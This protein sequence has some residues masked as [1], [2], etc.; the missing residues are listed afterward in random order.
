[1]AT[2]SITATI[3][4]GISRRLPLRPRRAGG[5]R[6]RHRRPLRHRRRIIIASTIVTIAAGAGEKAKAVEKDCPSRKS[7]GSLFRDFFEIGY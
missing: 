5:L 6:R 3:M 2:W 7:A 4:D 1:M